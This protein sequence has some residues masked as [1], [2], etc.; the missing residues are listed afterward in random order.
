MMIMIMMITMMRNLFFSRKKKASNHGNG[1][2]ICHSNGNRACLGLVY[3]V[4]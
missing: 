2:E 1:T 3:V 4:V